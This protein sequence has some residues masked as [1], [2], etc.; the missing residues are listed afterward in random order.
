MNSLKGN[1]TAL[2]V[3]LALTLFASACTGSTGAAIEQGETAMALNP[4]EGDRKLQLG[5]MVRK[6]GERVYRLERR[7]RL[8][9]IHP[10]TGSMDFVGTVFRTPSG[11]P[12]LVISED[13]LE[14]P[15]TLAGHI[16]DNYAGNPTGLANALNVLVGSSGPGVEVYQID[17]LGVA[18]NAVFIPVQIFAASGVDTGGGP[19]DE[20]FQLEMTL[21]AYHM[22]DDNFTQITSSTSPVHVFESGT[23]GE[24]PGV[25][26][27]E[28]VW[29]WEHGI[30]P[31]QRGTL[32]VS[33]FVK[34]VEIPGQPLSLTNASAPAPRIPYVGGS[35]MNPHFIAEQPFRLNSDL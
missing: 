14:A 31:E 33:V 22:A 1:R 12:T 25:V 32:R 34:A 18:S 16:E 24:Q 8:S 21:I 35:G 27:A 17:F 30:P 2:A 7:D 28:G 15:P 6:L 23:G 19:G 5:D 11:R 13:G 4:H 26:F 20:D 3:L 29:R 9:R 10:V